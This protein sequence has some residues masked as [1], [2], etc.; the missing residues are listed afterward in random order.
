MQSRWSNDKTRWQWKTALTKRCAPIREIQV[1]NIETTDVLKI[2][3]PIWTEIADT[4]ARTRMRI[5]SVL[6]YAKAK[7]QGC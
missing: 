7:G 5:E 1:A 4:A 2:L 3:N 6:D